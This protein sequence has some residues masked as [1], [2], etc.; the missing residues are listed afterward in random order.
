CGNI[1]WRDMKT[2]GQYCYAVSECEGSNAGIS[3]IDMQ[4]LPDSA[5]LIIS[6]VTSSF[7]TVTSHNLSVDSIA[8]FLYV[9]GQGSLDRNIYIHDLADP[10]NPIYVAGMGD[11]SGHSIHDIY[12][13]AD[14]V[15]VAEGSSSSFSIWDLTDKNNPQLLTRWTSPS[16]GYAHNIWPSEDHT[17]VATTEETSQRT[18][19]IWD[20]QDYQNVQLLGQYLAPAELAHNA[21]IRGD[22][23]Y[24]SH[25]ES[26][27]RVVD[28]S[29]PSNPSEIGA[30]DTYPT[31][32]ISTY[33]GAW[34]V[35][36]YSP[37]GYV[38]GSNGDGRL[39]ILQE[40]EF[41]VSDS[42]TVDSVEAS[43][44]AKIRVDIS[45][46]NALPVRQF[47]VPVTW[48][49]P[50]AVTLDSVSKV[51][52]RTEYFQSLNLVNFNPFASQAA[53][54][55]VS[56]SNGSA[57]DLDPGSGPILSL[58]FSVSGGS[59][60][61]FNPV[62]LTPVGGATAAVTSG[63]GVSLAPQT[64]DGGIDVCFVCGACCVTPGDGNHDGVFNI[65]DV[66]YGIAYI[67]SGGGAPACQDEADSNG[68][69]SFNISDVTYGITYIFSSGPA[70]VCGA[71][72]L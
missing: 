57:P 54:S 40:S 21:Q 3:V 68:D 38:F 20:I 11:I 51:G 2:M 64:L 48:A 18:V 22:R 34:G 46:H 9:E 12:V 1:F 56:S 14:T 19:K 55:L 31:S 25:Y 66:T 70:P 47:I 60:E 69:N 30:Y 59:A 58:Y 6:K 32:E 53:Y 41:A 29:D 49:G 4:Y 62:L 23:M 27:I 15:Y 33:N 16:G 50:A 17:L 39:F 44:G 10:T 67:F 52:T 13:Y 28:I 7:G 37:Y 65:S 43:P 63:C 72:G 26:G 8:G 35:Y 71:T 36:N 5:H 24:L 45:A 61:A 42:F